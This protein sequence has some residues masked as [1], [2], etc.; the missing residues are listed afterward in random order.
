MTQEEWRAITEPEYRQMAKEIS[1]EIVIRDYING[2]SR[3]T[4]R[5]TTKAEREILQN[6]IMGAFLAY[7]FQE[8]ADLY[9][10]CYTAEF[11]LRRFIPEANS[12]DSV[13]IPIRKAIGV[14]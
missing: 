7:S 11:T 2:N 12:Y 6:I 10:I 9:T 1:H 4:R 3:D 14:W 13:Y 5:P 8:N